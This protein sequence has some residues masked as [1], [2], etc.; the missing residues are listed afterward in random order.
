MAAA[1]ARRHET[2]ALLRAHLSAASGYRSGYRHLTR[3]CPVCH[4]LLRLAMEPSEN[5]PGTLRPG[6][7]PAPSEGPPGAPVG[8]SDGP[9]AAGPGESP[10]AAPAG[11]C[12]EPSAAPGET[13]D[14]GPDGE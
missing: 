8:A 13:R 11:R 6:L 10:A 1:T 9:P 3:D 4:R 12:A 14:E 7:V 2:K 5:E